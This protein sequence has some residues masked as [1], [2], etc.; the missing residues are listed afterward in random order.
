[1]HTVAKFKVSEIFYSIDGE[2]IRTG[3]PC[4][5]LRLHGC[6]LH[7][8]Y[9]DSRYAC[10]GEDYKQYTINEILTA[11]KSFNCNRVTLT[12]GEPLDAACITIL[13]RVLAS[14]YEVNIE[15]NGSIPLS[16]IACDCADF[17]DNLLI[18]MDWKCVSSGMSS[19]NCIDNLRQLR[20]QDVLKF[21]V[22]DDIDLLQMEDLLKTYSLDC[23]IFVSPVFGKIEPA[24]I[25]EFLLNHG[26]TD[27]R[28]QL[29]LHKFIWDSN[30]RGV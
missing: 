22:G 15:T 6:N 3:Y 7:C 16:L 21:V 17:Y 11:L 14:N 8:S 29:Q 2:G 26:L 23:N 27:V 5:F 19:Y 13:L 25:V 10:D 30:M 1:M 20:K 18:T 9:C 24:H 4:I 28:I 12:G